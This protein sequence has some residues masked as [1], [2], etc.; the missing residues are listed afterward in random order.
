[1]GEDIDLAAGK[2]KSEVI[3]HNG[4]IVRAGAQ[5][6]I[7]T[8]V[9]TA[10]NDILMRLVK[11]DADVCRLVEER[12]D[13]VGLALPGMPAGAPGMEGAGKVPYEVL[14]FSRSGEPMT[15]AER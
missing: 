8:P 7:P 1:M 13:V 5:A 2:G 6:G 10:L 11:G 12:P 15:Y 3:Y 14:A 4:A 9:N